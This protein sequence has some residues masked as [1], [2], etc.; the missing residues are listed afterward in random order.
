MKD[1]RVLFCRQ[2]WAPAVVVMVVPLAVLGA[3]RI[4]LSYLSER[5]PLISFYSSTVAV[6]W[7]RV[8]VLI[9][10]LSAGSRSGPDGFHWLSE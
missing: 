2:T 9:Y 10:I 5:C 3:A 8:F 6:V 7:P 4:G 1:L